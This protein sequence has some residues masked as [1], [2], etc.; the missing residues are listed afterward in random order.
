MRA[1]FLFIFSVAALIVSDLY[2]G[3]KNIVLNS[4]SENIFIDGY[5]NDEAWKSAT[6]IT[7]FYTLQPVEGQPADEKTALF[8]GYDRDYLYLALICFYDDPSNI[9]ATVAKRDEIFEDDFVILYLDTFDDGK[10]AYQF[11]FNPY[12]IQADGI[13]TEHVGEDFKPDFIFESK[14]RI[15]QKGYIVESR[16]PFSSLN[17]PDKNVMNWRLGVMRRTQFLNHDVVWPAFTR[18]STEWVGQF[19][20]L[21]EIHSIKTGK[22]LEILPEFSSFRRDVLTANELKDGPIKGEPGLNVKF[23]VTSGLNL[24][25]TFNPDFSQIESDENKI[26]VNRIKPLYFKEK[27][28]FFLEGT[29][30]FETPIQAVYTRQIVNP[31]AGIKLSGRS[32]DYSIGLLST[33]D[34]YQGS[35]DYLIEKTNQNGLYY[36]MPEYSTYLNGLDK[37]YGDKKSLNN[38]LHVKRNILENSSVGFL[39]TDREFEDSFNRVYGLD[40]RFAIT[41]N[42]VFTVQGLYSQTKDLNSTKSI[43]DPAFYGNFFHT[44]D[45][46]NIQLFYND[47]APDFRVENGFIERADISSQGFREAGIQ[48]WYNFQWKDR[49]LQNFTPYFYTTRIYDY[50][51]AVIENN[52]VPYIN[53]KFDFKTDLTL[54]YY[55]SKEFYNGSN[56]NKNDYVIDI[57]NSYFQWL[58]LDL[59]HFTGDEIYYYSALPFLGYINYNSS[60]LVLKPL[61]FINMEFS[62]RYYRFTGGNGG[63]N[64]GLTQDIPR[65][66]VTYQLNQNIAFRIIGEQVREKYD[67]P[68]FDYLNSGQL[69]FNFLASY[70][71][72][73]G[74]VVFLGYNDLQQR[75]D[76][77]T[78][79]WLFNN[80]RRSQRGFFL[81]LSYLFRL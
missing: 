42:Y 80:Y 45:N 66:K 67:D 31:L 16:I 65:L 19:G 8:L 40:G 54:T 6:R 15:F 17:F 52:L 81:K 48:T 23:G 28:P 77:Y 27:R 74:T 69:D 4:L 21:Q 68:A 18:N 5:L 60:S 39:A 11:A 62:Y 64:Y 9:R 3:S 37:K 41:S 14:G 59:H 24:D 22:R 51:G 58:Q 12:G 72:S 35:R 25:V 20:K 76:N 55:Y 43:Q 2:A 7:D 38:I 13:F 29:E 70:T 47:Y 26:D 78:G 46:W 49:S 75:N 63:V 61:D 30:I 36:W 53:L 32:G 1:W 56:F 57:Q 44:S 34:E 73:P 71:P 50:N 10:Y 79:G 33:L